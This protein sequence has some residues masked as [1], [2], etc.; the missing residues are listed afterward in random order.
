V[1]GVSGNEDA[2]TKSG[3]SG[4]EFNLASNTD[5]RISSSVTFVDTLD[6]LFSHDSEN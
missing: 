2:G 3:V 1:F 5:K 4:I 6:I